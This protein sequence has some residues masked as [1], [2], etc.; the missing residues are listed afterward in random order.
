MIGGMTMMVGWMLSAFSPR[1]ALIHYDVFGPLPQEIRP[2]DVTSIETVYFLVEQPK[3]LGRPVRATQVSSSR[4]G[5]IR[6]RWTTAAAPLRGVRA[7]LTVYSKNYI[8][9]MAYAHPAP[10]KPGK[11]S[12]VP[13]VLKKDAEMIKGRVFDQITGKAVPYPAFYLDVSGE[14]TARGDVDG[15]YTLWVGPQI[16]KSGV[17]LWMPDYIGIRVSLDGMLSNPNL[18]LEPA[19]V[20]AVEVVDSEGQPIKRPLK[21]LVEGVYHST[22]SLNKEGRAW[23]DHFAT[24]D[25]PHFQLEV[26]DAE[27][28][29]QILPPLRS[30]ARLHLKTPLR[31]E[32]PASK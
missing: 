2:E 5:Q 17:V 8:P 6:S 11:W 7:E 26:E 32:L 29:A 30:D 10:D 1:S 18:R 14:L 21:L 19:Y 9:L 23:L 3:T 31:I 20:V 13:P 16:R 24:P 15:N 22:V 12:F 25:R 4:E 27:G 28:R